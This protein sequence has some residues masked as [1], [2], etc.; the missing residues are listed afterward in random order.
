MMGFVSAGSL[1]GKATQ[2]RRACPARVQMARTHQSWSEKGVEIIN[3]NNSA[4]KNYFCGGFPGGEVGLQTWIDEGMR[5]D[6]PDLVANFQPSAGIKE[7][8]NQAE[9]VCYPYL[10]R[11]F[12]VHWDDALN[13]STA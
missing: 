5:E 8:D 9:T 1:C 6:V 4:W 7:D 3:D 12:T 10:G 11:C 13:P 2:A